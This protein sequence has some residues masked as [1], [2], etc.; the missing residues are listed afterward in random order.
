MI[1]DSIITTTVNGMAVSFPYTIPTALLTN[2]FGNDGGDWVGNLAGQKSVGFTM[3]VDPLFCGTGAE[4]Y[5]LQDGSPCLAPNNPTGTIGAFGGG[6]LAVSAVT[7]GTPE[8]NGRIML[9]ANVPNP[10]N[11]E[12]DIRFT[13]PSAGRVRLDIHGIDGRRVAT[14]ADREFTAGP[15]SLRWDARDDRGRRMASGI[16]LCRL[17]TGAVQETIKMML[18]K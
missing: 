3:S 18:L 11:P 9:Q 4:P 5:R 14:L 13:L 10:F 12:T 17:E 7:E 16:Y 6:C 8:V 2:L 1:I 15:H